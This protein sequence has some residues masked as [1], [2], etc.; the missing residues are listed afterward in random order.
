MTGLIL[1]SIWVVVV[2]SLQVIYYVYEEVIST[3]QRL[4]Q[5]TLFVLACLWFVWLPV[6]ILDGLIK[7]LVNTIKRKIHEHRTKKSV[8]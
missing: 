8:G 2:I 1:F 3:Y 6:Y 4:N 5:I 7:L